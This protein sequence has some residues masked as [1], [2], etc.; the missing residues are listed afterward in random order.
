MQDDPRGP[1]ED[2]TESFADILKEFETAGRAAPAG[3]PRRGT[4][5]G[6]SGD[7]VLVD[8]GAKAEGVIPAADLRDSDGNLTVKRGDTFDVAVTGRNN[9]G[10]TTLSLVKGRR[11]RDWDALKQAFD[12][13][14]IVAGRVTGTVKGGFTVDLGARAFL[15]ASRSGTRTP[16]DMQQLV[17]QEIRCRII[18][19]D[20]ND[21]DVVVDR[22][23]GMEDEAKQARQRSIN[24]R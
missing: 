16:E 21:E 6:V 14:Q 23:S 13:K 7:Y 18:K 3:G 24:A 9:E 5:V 17:G 12:N 1:D 4:V 15:P 8:Y 11:P 19:F 2:K 10:M 22:R 20:A